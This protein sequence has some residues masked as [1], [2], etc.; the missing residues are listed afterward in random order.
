M[1]GELVVLTPA[2]AAS[3]WHVQT[4]RLSALP[5]FDRRAIEAPVA[6]DAKA[7]QASLTEQ[8][9]DCSWMYAQVVGQLL[10]RE[11]IVPR[12]SALGRAV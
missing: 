9:I 4:R 6:A 7:G 1:G 8:T 5:L 12:C 3:Y 11:D 10:N 2:A